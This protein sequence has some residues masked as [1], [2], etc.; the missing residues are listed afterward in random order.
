MSDRPGIAN[1]STLR[2]ARVG[3]R[4]PGPMEDA[5]GALRDEHDADADDDLVHAQADAVD[6]HDERDGDADEAAAEQAQPRVARC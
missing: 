2:D 4:E 1:P 5:R 3:A 6:D